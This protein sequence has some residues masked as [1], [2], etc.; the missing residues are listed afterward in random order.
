MTPEERAKRTEERIQRLK[1]TFSKVQAAINKGADKIENAGKKFDNYVNLQDNPPA[2]L[3]N[4][5]AEKPPSAPKKTK[6]KK[7]Y[8]F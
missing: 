5:V 1:D 6:T 3:A 4:D 2:P 8:R 7:I